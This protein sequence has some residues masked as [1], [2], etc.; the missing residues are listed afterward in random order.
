MLYKPR[1]QQYVSVVKNCCVSLE[2]LF[3][4]IVQWFH[5]CYRCVQDSSAN[6]HSMSVYLVEPRICQYK[7]VVS[8][9]FHMTLSGKP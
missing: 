9:V 6:Q 4:D 1:R 3:S 8:T 2:L 7:L 5:V